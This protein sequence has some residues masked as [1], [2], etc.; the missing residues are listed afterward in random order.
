MLAFA[1]VLAVILG[2]AAFIWQSRRLRDQEAEF[3]AQT[4][5]DAHLL[6]LEEVDRR[7][8]RGEIVLNAQELPVI[9]SSTQQARNSSLCALPGCVTNSLTA[10]IG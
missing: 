6:R 1:V 7:L 10:P 3:L 8:G 2:A 5:D 9:A 4:K